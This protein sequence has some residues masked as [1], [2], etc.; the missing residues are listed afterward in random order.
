[1]SVCGG[2]YTERSGSFVVCYIDGMYCMPALNQPIFRSNAVKHYIESREKHEFPRFMSLPIAILLWV[3]LTLFVAATA[4]V[5]SERVP[6]Y[7]TTQ[8]IVVVQ[9]AAQS[10]G[11][12]ASATGKQVPATAVGKS[13]FA[14]GKQVPEIKKPIPSI[15]VGVFFFPPAQAQN[16]HTGIPV[17]LHVGPSGSQF[18]SQIAA[19]GPGVMSPETLRAVFHLENASLPITQPSTVVIV[20]L[21]P[22]FANAYAGSTVTANL[23]VGSERLISL[24]PGVGNLFKGGQTQ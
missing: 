17:R 18:S 24:L 22:A 13:A 11:E 16:L 23:Q 5:W 19:I 20:K 6:I 7:A 12:S 2:R 3:L 15:A 1:M 4:L 10:S 14:I 8:G 21:N 9:P